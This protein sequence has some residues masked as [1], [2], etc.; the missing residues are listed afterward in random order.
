[1]AEGSVAITIVV[2]VDDR[3]A[4]EEKYRWDGLQPHGTGQEPWRATLVFGMLLRDRLGEG[5][6]DD[7]SAHVRQIIGKRIRRRVW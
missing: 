3:F 2:H 4:V 5:S 6:V 7:W 1:M